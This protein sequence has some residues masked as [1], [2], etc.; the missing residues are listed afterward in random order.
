MAARQLPALPQ[1]RKDAVTRRLCASVHLDTDF[2]HEADHRLTGDGL[3]AMGPPLGVNLVALA[4]HARVAVRSRAALDRRLARLLLAGWAALLFGV[5]ALVKGYGSLAATAVYGPLAV[6]AAAWWLVHRHEARA[7]AAAQGV[8][9]TLTR[10]ED[11]APAVE[12]EAED[13]L[14]E[15]RK[16]NV[17][18]YTDSAERTNPFVG[19]GD[20][21]KETLWQPI[22]VSRPADSPTGGKL[23]VRPF[24][25]VDL[26]TY[27]AREMEGV[28]GLEGLRARNRL[29]VIGSNVLHL[30]DLL[31]DRAGRPR[32]QIPRQLV[33]AGL[34]NPGAGMRTYLCLERVGEGGRTI[35]SMYLRARLHRPSLTWEVAAYAIPP[36]HGRF[37]RVDALPVARAERWWNLLTYATTHVWPELSG[38]VRRLRTRRRHRREADRAL[39][40]TRREIREHHAVY[41]YGASDS[42]RERYGDW[43][44]AGYSEKTDAQDFLFRLQQGVLVATERFLQD[45]NVDTGS[46]DKAQ[47]II[48]TQTYNIS[49]DIN[50]PSN[51]GNQGQITMAGGQQQ[52]QGGGQQGTGP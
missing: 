48:S 45:H 22:D 14:R 10:A 17:V 9:R 20:K 23:T 6:L 42:L 52:G 44:Q 19:S 13:R 43:S 51:I 27:V 25:A 24:D 29:Y 1:M 36:L 35:V 34:Q 2:A 47:Q 18:P 8:Y 31:P 33:Q 12:P 21:I 16:A 39:A 38:A 28:S 15:L 5:G 49:G 30:P 37:H 41:D 7:W 50:G 46:F 32:A 40:R 11:L 3:N 26:H 4:R